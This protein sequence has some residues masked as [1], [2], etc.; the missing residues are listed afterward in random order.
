[1]TSPPGAGS[2]LSQASLGASRPHGPR[3]NKR[4]QSPRRLRSPH[5]PG[6]RGARAGRPRALD[7]PAARGHPLPAREL[8]VLF[9]ARDVAAAERRPDPPPVP[10]G[11]PLS[12]LFAAAALLALSAKIG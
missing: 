4:R 1:C 2:R 8:H 3:Y 5:H 11:P 6:R 12:S 9:P 10:A 7:R